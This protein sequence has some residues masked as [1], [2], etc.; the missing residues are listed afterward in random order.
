M[1]DLAGYFIRNHGAKK[2]AFLRGPDSHASALDRFNGFRAALREAGFPYDDRFVTDPF[3]WDEGR[4]ACTQL[5]EARG[6][7][8]GKDFDALIG[9][10][11]MMILSAI[12]YLAGHGYTAPEDYRAGGFSNSIES[13]D[14]VKPLLDSTDALRGTKR[15]VLQNT[16]APVRRRFRGNHAGCR[17]ALRT[18]HP[19]IRT[20]YH[21][22][23][24]PIIKTL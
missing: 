11:D 23:P 2:I 9:S 15:G 20:G 5:Y 16:K 7:R 10:S 6:L 21:P 12:Q 19:G 1:K 14:T 8:P 24:P 3:R 4:A 18:Y 22:P 13:K 17:A